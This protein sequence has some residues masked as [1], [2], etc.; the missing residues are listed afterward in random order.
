MIKRGA[1]RKFSETEEIN[2]F[3]KILEGSFEKLKIA[4]GKR[5]FEDFNGLKRIIIQTQRKMWIMLNRDNV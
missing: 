5:D 4:Y 1:E 3:V 2:Q